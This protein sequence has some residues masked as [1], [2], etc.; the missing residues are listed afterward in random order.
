VD[1]ACE[2]LKPEG[3]IVHYYEFAEGLNAVE[4]AKKH[5]SEAISKTGRSISGF[6]S[7]RTVREV[8]P[9]KFQVV[10]DAIIRKKSH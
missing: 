3:G 1:V 5:L 8:A 7:A 2:A 4:V 10:V 9:F 6:S